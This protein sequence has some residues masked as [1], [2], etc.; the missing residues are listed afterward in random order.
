M[1]VDHYQFVSFSF[2]SF[3]MLNSYSV[4]TF[5][6]ITAVRVDIHQLVCKTTAIDYALI[7]LNTY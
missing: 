3:Q 6:F 7:E 4:K 2:R 5:H 1:F